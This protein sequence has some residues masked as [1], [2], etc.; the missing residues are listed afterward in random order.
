[1]RIDGPKDLAKARK[2]TSTNK[3]SSGGASFQI[4]EPYQSN[5]ISSA[6]APQG[7]NHISSLIAAQE[8]DGNTGQAEQAIKRGTDMLD[9]LDQLKFG[10]LNGRISPKALNRLRILTSEQTHLSENEGLKSVLQS[11]EL[12]AEVELAKLA[13]QKKR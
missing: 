7:I 4:N 11:I 6:Q 1:M 2:K 8:V 10:V 13:Q 3:S 9:L 12:R 5:S